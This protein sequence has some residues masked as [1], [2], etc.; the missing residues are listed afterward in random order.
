LTAANEDFYAHRMQ[1]VSAMPPPVIPGDMDTPPQAADG[2]TSVVLFIL[3][4]AL[5]ATDLT[6]EFYRGVSM[7]LQTFELLIFVS[8]LA[9]IAFHWWKRIDERRRSRHLDRELA[10]ARAE[11]RRW[12]EDAR[13][14]NEEAQH[15]LDG[16][17]AAMDRQFDRWGLTPA[18]REVALLQ[19]KGL[20][21]KA[22]AEVRHTSERTVRQQA[23]AIYRKSGL[24][25]RTDLAAFFLED[26]LLPGNVR[27]VRHLT[28]A[29]GTNV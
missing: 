10:A 25:G 23:L 9:G 21:H 20:R 12:S 24:S 18:E 13:R 19:L 14:W 6:I 2:R 5:M 4:A 7:A 29:H 11:A 26:L 15:V 28:H 27:N 22:I 1:Q 17:G 16:L 8:A 3:I